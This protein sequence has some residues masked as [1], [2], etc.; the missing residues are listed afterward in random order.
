MEFE[1]EICL[2]LLL[3]HFDGFVFVNCII[4]SKIVS[5][6]SFSL[7]IP[8]RNGIV[9]EVFISELSFLDWKIIEEIHT[10]LYLIK[11]I[12]NILFQ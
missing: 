6:G 11:I 10:L 7:I 2:L 8:E 1:K 5:S 12:N 9:F 4:E 3:Y